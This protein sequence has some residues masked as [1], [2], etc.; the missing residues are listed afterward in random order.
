[1]DMLIRTSLDR[2]DGPV[3]AKINEYL[4][5]GEKVELCY[6]SGQVTPQTPHEVY[7]L[8]ERQ[9]ITIQIDKAIHSY[10]SDL[11]EITSIKEPADPVEIRLGRNSAFVYR[12]Q[13]DRSVL[14]F[15]TEG[16]AAHFVFM[17]KAFVQVADLKRLAQSA[18]RPP[19][20]DQR[21]RK[22]AQLHKEGLI[23]DTEFQQKRAEILREL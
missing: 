1:M 4:F 5:E 8:T 15:N 21:F 19:D 3:R 17:L 23:T 7:A 20:A 2:L 6:Q 9:F 16:E 10:T 22:L 13:V 11:L 18:S 14:P 12:V